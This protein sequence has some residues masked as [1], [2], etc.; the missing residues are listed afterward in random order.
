MKKYGIPVIIVAFL[1]LNISLAQAQETNIG[2]KGG[3]ALY[4]TTLSFSGF[5]ESLDETSDMRTGFAAGLFVEKPF[6][7]IVS[8]QF[9]GLFVQKGGKDEVEQADVDVDV[10][11]GDLTLSYVDVPV[12]LKVNIPLD[13]NIKPFLYGGGFAGFL[14]DAEAEADGQSAGD[15]GIEIKDLLEDLNYGA[16]FGGGVS[17]GKISIDIRYD[18][19]IANIFDKDSD[20]INEL[21]DEAGDELDG[22]DGLDELLDGIEITTSGL[23]VTF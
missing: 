16:V 11:D 14:I 20:F 19:G 2:L 12:M 18:L 21:I 3:A 13:G 8:I 6:S 15:A 1:A 23:G 17:F 5:G 22:L 9:E 4:S 10:E 7:D